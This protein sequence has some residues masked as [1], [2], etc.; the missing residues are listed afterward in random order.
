MNIRQDDKR[1]EK[2]SIINQLS[3]NLKKKERK[4]SNNYQLLYQ[5]LTKERKKRKCNNFP[6]EQRWDTLFIYL[7]IYVDNFTSAV[8]S[9]ADFTQNNTGMRTHRY[10]RIFLKLK[11]LSRIQHIHRANQLLLSIEQ[12]HRCSSLSLSLSFK[13]T[14][15]TTTT[16]TTQLFF[17]INA[18]FP[19]NMGNHVYSQLPFSLI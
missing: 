6:N 4:T 3:F 16:A 2:Y 19:H 15:P 11:Y 7:F 10:A 18:M 1:L 5:S 8:L 9:T 13:Y 12:A 17:L 14:H